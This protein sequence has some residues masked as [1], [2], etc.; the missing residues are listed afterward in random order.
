[1]EVK[2]T[3][4]TSN[5]SAVGTTFDGKATSTTPRAALSQLLREAADQL[6]N[7]GVDDINA[8]TVSGSIT[9]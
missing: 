7:D 5:D 3:L 6:D 2:F 4:V 1:M 8:L 9:P